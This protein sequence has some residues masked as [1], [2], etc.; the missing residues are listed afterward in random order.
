M[1]FLYWEMTYLGPDRVLG[2]PVQ[3]F[4]LRPNTS[5]KRQN[6]AV[7]SGEL[8]LDPAWGIWLKII[9]KSIGGEILRYINVLQLRKIGPSDFEETIDFITFPDRTKVRLQLQCHI[10]AIAPDP[11]SSQEKAFFT[12]DK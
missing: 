6:P 2:R 5:Q 10:D 3:R 8:A 7:A 4:L 12:I 9:Y 1:P 11:I